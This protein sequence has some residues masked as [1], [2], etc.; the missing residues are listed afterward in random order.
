MNTRADKTSL[1]L[2]LCSYCCQRLAVNREHVIARGFFPKPRPSGLPCVPACRE[3]NAGRGDG[4]ATDLSVDEEYVR[5]MMC[6]EVEASRHPDAMKLI[7]NEIARSVNRSLLANTGFARMLADSLQVAT[8]TND[9][10][11][12][13]GRVGLMNISVPRIVR[14]LQKITRG[15]FYYVHNRPLPPAVR[16]WVS[17]TL[18]QERAIPIRDLMGRMKHRTG[19]HCHGNLKTVCWYGATWGDPTTSTQFMLLTVFYSRFVFYTDT[20]PREGGRPIFSPSTDNNAGEV[21]GCR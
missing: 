16:P 13:L 17:A 4:E 19:W 5:T 1:T 14:V 21:T 15:L 7:T 12:V 8:A 11:I 10:G 3:C 9:F 2:G 6:A 18:S 20:V